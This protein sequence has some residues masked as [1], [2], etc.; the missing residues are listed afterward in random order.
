MSTPAN[1]LVEKIRGKF[2]G[3]YDDISD[4]DLTQKILAKHPE[5]G[6]LATAPSS[7]SLTAQ[8][9]AAASAGG[10]P[11]P[12]VSPTPLPGAGQKI[13]GGTFPSPLDAS[14]MT[15]AGLAPN[16]Q[17]IASVPLPIEAGYMSAP[18]M[19][20]SVA[21]SAFSSKLAQHYFPDNPWA[22]DAAGFAGGALGSGS[23]AQVEDAFKPTGRTIGSAVRTPDGAL[24]PGVVTAARVAGGLAG[25][26]FGTG[27]TIIG[28]MA[29]PSLA[30]AFLPD[31]PETPAAQL[32]NKTKEIT[33][34]QESALS[35]NRKFD[36][37]T[38]VDQDRLARQVQQ[39]KDARDQAFN[40]RAQSMQMQQAYQ[41]KLD[42]AKLK[43]D[44][45]LARSQRNAQMQQG[46]DM[47]A[48]IEYNRNVAQQAAEAAEENRQRNLQASQAEDQRVQ[49]L[50]DQFAKSLSDL[51]SHR[52]KTLADQGRLNNQWGDAL[53][54]RGGA[55]AAISPN[56]PQELQGNPTP[57]SPSFTADDI[58]SR[59]RRL[60]IPDQE[61]SAADIKKAND[62]TNIKTDKLKQL[63]R[64]GDMA[65][66]NEL[67]RRMKN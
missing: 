8:T 52:Q 48:E 58:I 2:P 41:D 60:T 14:G 29:G 27:G 39:A 26:P 50:H 18:R 15:K 54:R 22:S 59:T 4:T 1:A 30:D 53:N 24:K 16:A 44:N 32:F 37:R 51:E 11:R 23:G 57:F 9:N 45:A 13:F 42:A 21:G 36:R 5:Y 49:D 17:P 67:N 3:V 62:A 56:A 40:D 35:D 55:S 33:E 66:K 25:S 31:S 12:G 34:A 63:A 61:L 65:A 6:D 28:G 19:I 10:A 38:Q 46:T 43:A 47:S 20:G 7:A 64:F